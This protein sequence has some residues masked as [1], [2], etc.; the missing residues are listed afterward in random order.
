M[1]I[2]GAGPTGLLAACQL[3]RFGCKLIIIDQRSR[4]TAESRAIILKWRSL[5]I[6]QQMGRQGVVIKPNRFQTGLFLLMAQ[7]KAR[8]NLPDAGAALTG[9]PEFKTFEQYKNEEL[10]YQS[11]YAP[12]EK[13]NG[14]LNS[15]VCF[16]RK[17][18]QSSSQPVNHRIALPLTIK[19]D[20][21][22]SLR[23]RIK[24]SPPCPSNEFCRGNLPKKI[25]VVNAKIKRH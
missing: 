20:F 14:I 16:S 12:V 18:R 2:I 9:F 11:L 5:E 17:N 1:I 4:P 15:S 23:R 21:H 19:A 22:F 3:A 6:Y 24:P 25:S 10:L 8:F 7:K 13:Y